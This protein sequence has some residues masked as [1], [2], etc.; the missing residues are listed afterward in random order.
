MLVGL[1]VALEVVVVGSS[2]RRGTSV[3]T[4]L[5]REPPLDRCNSAHAVRRMD[6]GARSRHRC[7]GNVLVAVDEEWVRLPT[8]D[9]THCA[10]G[11]V[12]GSVNGCSICFTLHID[13]PNRGIKGPLQWR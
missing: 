9:R 12:V 13:A 6:T 3:I 10:S 7:G 4:H 8:A 11:L 2:E 1:E 5:R